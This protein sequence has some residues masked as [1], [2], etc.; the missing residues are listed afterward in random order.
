MNFSLAK[1]HWPCLIIIGVH[2]LCIVIADPRGEF[3]LND[4]WSYSRSAFSAALGNLKVD[5]WSAPSL[6]GQAIYGGFLARIFSPDF[7]VLRISTLFLSCCTVLLLWGILIRSGCRRR[8]ASVL[9]LAWIFNP[10]QFGLSFTFMT[11]VP[12]LFFVALSV[13]LFVRHMET[14]RVPTLLLSAASLGYAYLIRQTALLI[15][16]ALVCTLLLGA[17][18]KTRFRDAFL[19]LCTAGIF[20]AAYYVW[21]LTRGG[22]TA[23]VQKKF[24]LLQH[25]TARQFIGNSYGMLFYLAFLLAPVWLFLIPRLVRTMREFRPVLRIGIPAVLAAMILTGVLWFHAG[26]RPGEY[27]PSAPYHPR[28]PFLLN[29]LYDSGL[30]PVT[31]EPDYYG[32]PST[33]VHTDIWRAVTA[34]AAAGAVVSLCLCLFG[35]MR[36]ICSK[37]K[38]LILFAGLS[39][40][41]LAAF[42]IVFSHLQEGGLF[43]RHILIV[44]FPFCLLLWLLS[45]ES[46]GLPARSY[47]AIPAGVALAALA[48]FSVAA[49][50]DYMEWNRIRWDMGRGLLARGVDP[51]AI[52]GG[53]EFNAWNNY[54]TFAAGGNV[55]KVYYWWY[56]RRD[57]VISMSPQSEYEV[58]SRR[59]YFSWVHLRPVSLYL[60]YL[61]Q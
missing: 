23:A 13:Y 18:K 4:D 1:K 27:L 41:F 20:I 49:T 11:E 32:T 42:E 55:S 33:P 60:L 61:T 16:A 59:E 8:P 56:D 26:Y 37:S 50:H 6:V 36:K 38:P 14:G 45:G 29:V 47:R 30:G 25:L 28:M 21:V 22:T 3:P 24:A 46:E 34:V 48:A 9:L 57:Y 52:V 31:L 10:L 19:V 2:L 54:D 51:M 40:L 44:S 39:F 12:F 7:L 53:F 15:V 43:D 35:L 5:Q 58:Q 17:R